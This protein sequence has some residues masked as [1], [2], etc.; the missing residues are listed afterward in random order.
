MLT[1]IVCGILM[2]N[3]TEFEKQT[4][5]DRDKGYIGNPQYSAAVT[6]PRNQGS[7][8]KRFRVPLVPNCKHIESEV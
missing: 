8:S 3:F 2:S 7:V 6:V 5:E 1:E 4:F